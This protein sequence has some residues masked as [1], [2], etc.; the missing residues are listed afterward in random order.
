MKGNNNKIV[1][2][3]SPSSDRFQDSDDIHQNECATCGIFTNQNMLCGRCRSVRY[4]RS[5]NS[6]QSSYKKKNTF[7]LNFLH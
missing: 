2:A 1:L 4:C 7:K 6:N 5:V 3:D